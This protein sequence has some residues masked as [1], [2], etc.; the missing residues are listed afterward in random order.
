VKWGKQPLRSIIKAH[1]HVCTVCRVTVGAAARIIRTWYDNR[2]AKYNKEV[3][4]ASTK[5][6]G[7]LPQTIAKTPNSAARKKVKSKIALGDGGTQE[8]SKS[9]PRKQIK[10]AAAVL[11]SSQETMTAKT[12]KRK[13][14]K[15]SST[16]TQK[17]KRAKK[18]ATVESSDDTESQKE[19]WSGGS[20]SES[21]PPTSPTQLSESDESDD[22]KK[23]DGDLAAED[24]VWHWE[25]GTV[26]G[27]FTNDNIIA[28]YCDM[29]NAVVDVS[30]Y[31]DI[32]EDNG[33]G[34]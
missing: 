22:A 13:R 31:T 6:A 28:G 16:K 10:K 17:K 27:L 20:G 34:W 7:P 23:D 24:D 33:C 5:Q 32:E 18:K 4:E 3:T 19:T 2:R 11:T 12:P 25:K 14:G 9:P 26:M 29:D 1:H 30:M 15:D 21:P 8:G